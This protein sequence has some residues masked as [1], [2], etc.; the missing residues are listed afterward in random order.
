MCVVFFFSFSFR[1]VAHKPVVV[2]TEV[3]DTPGS[4]ILAIEKSFSDVRKPPVHPEH[5]HLKADQILDILP[6]EGIANEFLWAEFDSFPVPP[7]DTANVETLNEEANKL[8]LK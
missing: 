5:K 8:L 6:D 2:S 7:T 4:E 3:D 1:R